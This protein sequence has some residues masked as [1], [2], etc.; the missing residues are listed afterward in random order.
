MYLFFL[1]FIYFLLLTVLLGIA[2]DVRFPIVYAGKFE[3]FLIKCGGPLLL[4]I[5]N[6]YLHLNLHFNKFCLGNWH[7]YM[8][9]PNGQHA[10]FACKFCMLA[11]WPSK[12]NHCQFPKQNFLKLTGSYL[13][14]I[15]T[16]AAVARLVMPVV[17]FAS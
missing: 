14:I 5:S 4:C 7:C 10:N 15:Y 8:L 9:R 1:C 16:V 3:G 17:F 12:Y 2:N 6:R 13:Y 11:I